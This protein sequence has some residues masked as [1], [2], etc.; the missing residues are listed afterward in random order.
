[1]SA[2]S[3]FLLLLLTSLVASAYAADRP[4]ILLCVADDWGWPHA[5]VYGDAVVNTDAFNRVASEGVLFS[6]AFVS[7][8][9]CTPSRNALLTGQQFYRLG[10]GANLHSSLH[11]KHPNFMLMLR[12]AGYSIGHFRKAWGPGD[13]RALGYTESPIGKHQGFAKF[14]TDRDQ[15][16]PFCFWLGTQDPHRGYKAGSGKASGMDLSKVRVPEFYPDVPETRSD[17]A[18]Y[19][20]EVQRWNQDVAKAIDLLEAIGELENTLI[21]VTGDHGMPFPRCKGNLYDWGTRVPLAVRWGERIHPKQRSD[22]LVSLTDLAPTFLQA[23][24]IEVPEAM[25]GKSLLPLMTSDPESERGAERDF[26]VYGRERHVPAQKMPSMLGYP[27]RAIRTNEWLLIVNLTPD[28][29]PAGV[30]EGATHPITRFADCDDGPTKSYLLRNQ[31]KSNVGNLTN[32][33]SRNVLPWNSTTA[34][35][36]RTNC[37]ILRR[38]RNMWTWS[39]NCSKSSQTTFALQETPVSPRAM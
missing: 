16:K 1:M 5:G 29:W 38:T 18:D 34:S 4:N 10:Q 13:M 19:Y 37:T 26:L 12:D 36:T 15:S 24:G 8:P 28:R 6:H 35:P 31:T 17:I 32:S 20:Y 3:L 14:L 7:S 30:P 21:V 25:T 11:P 23:A 9:S 22:G 33:A 27:S 39:I 2:R